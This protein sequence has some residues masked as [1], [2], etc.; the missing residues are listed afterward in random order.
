MVAP[1]SAPPSSGQTG[2][3][4]YTPTPQ[5]EHPYQEPHQKGLT[6]TLGIQIFRPP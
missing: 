6:H 2:K 4:T 1:Q 5:S 3:Q